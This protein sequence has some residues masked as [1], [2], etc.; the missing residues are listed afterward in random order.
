MFPATL[1]AII[2]IDVKWHRIHNVA[3]LVLIFESQLLNTFHLTPASEAFALALSLILFFTGGGGGDIKFALF[4]LSGLL[5]EQNI[6]SYLAAFSAI[7]IVQ[8]VF[9]F[10][11]TGECRGAVPLAPSLVGA[12]LL[13]T[14]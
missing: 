13:V 7:A 8:L 2:A 5:S 9:R 11:T 1:I 6:S 10:V 3:I 14:I 12:L 4:V